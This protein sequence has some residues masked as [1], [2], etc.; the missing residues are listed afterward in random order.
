MLPLKCREQI[1]LYEQDGRREGARWAFENLP[2]RAQC[3]FIATSLYQ[4]GSYAV[5]L[6]AELDEPFSNDV[7]QRL[8]LQYRPAQSSKAFDWEKVS[9]NSHIVVILRLHP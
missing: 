6:D 8:K 3:K 2:R 9:G 7:W 5:Y 1:R 4:L